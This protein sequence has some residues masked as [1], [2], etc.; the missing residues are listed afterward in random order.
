M[1]VDLSAKDVL[2]EQLKERK[3]NKKCF[4]R[5]ECFP[6]SNYPCELL[7]VTFDQFLFKLNKWAVRLQ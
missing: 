6:R 4:L 2:S 1:Q 7:D 3:M 5:V